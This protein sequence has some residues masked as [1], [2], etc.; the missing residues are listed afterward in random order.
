MHIYSALRLFIFI[1]IPFFGY[2]QESFT[3]MLEYKISIR[4]TSMKAFVPDNRMVIYTNDTI[5]RIENYTPRLGKQVVI[6]HMLLNKSYML[7]DTPVGKFAIQT[8]HN[9]SDTA[10]TEALYTMKK[11]CGKERIL[12]FKSKRLIVTYP[13]MEEELAFL[14]LKQ[15][16][17][18]Y[19]NNFEK[20]P[21]LLVKYSLPTEDGILDYE[22]VRINQ[23]IPDKDMF[24]IPSDYERVS[25]NEF[26]SR[27]LNHHEEEGIDPKDDN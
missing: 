25:F 24:G 9:K 6:H 7:L 4:D 17:N 10:R 5:T 15:Y 19:L 18:K 14:Y 8:D 26:L 21:G 20:S 16:S 11:K 13:D 1:V 27:F 12:G 3:G 22:L 2:S 23:Y